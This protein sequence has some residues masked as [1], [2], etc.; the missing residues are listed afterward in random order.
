[1]RK[2][3]FTIVSAWLFMVWCAEGAI[4]QRE[5]YDP[6]FVIDLGQ[7]LPSYEELQTFYREKHTLYD[8]KYQWHWAIGNVFDAAFRATINEYGHAEKRIKAENEQSLLDALELLPKEYYQYIGPYLHTVPGIS[9]KILNLP[10]IKETKNQFPK[11]LAPQVAD[12][13]DIEYLS[14][15]LYFLLMPEAWPG[16]EPSE[17]PLPKTKPVKQV[18]NHELYELIKNI[19][20]ADDFYPDATQK[21]GLD[22]S[23]LRSLQITA[24]SPLTS[25]DIRAFV[26]TLPKLNELQGNIEAMAKIYG[27][28]SLLDYWENEQGKSLPVSSFKDLVAPCSRLLQKMRVADEER[29]LKLIVANDGFTPEGW[30]YTCDKTIRAY[31]LATLSASTAQSLKAYALGA[32]NQEIRE[33]LGDKKAQMQFVTMQAALRMHESSRHDVLEVYKNR[34][35]LRESFDK[36]GYSIIAAPIAVSN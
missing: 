23:D 35:L 15:Y 21:K 11:R 27:A 8:R 6:L 10:G 14:P 3:L 19:V 26:R 1:M 33:M 25:G 30:A 5:K 36:A 16:N 13:P 18:R 32:Y 29:Y 17:V 7:E 4:P 20:P 12:I 28:G 22:P 9:D 31:R 24:T 2:L 34:E